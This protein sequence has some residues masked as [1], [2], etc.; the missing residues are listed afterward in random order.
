MRLYI[1]MVIGSIAVGALQG[2]AEALRVQCAIADGFT[3]FVVEFRD[4]FLGIFTCLLLRIT[5]DHV[6]TQSI[7]QQAVVF[8]R[9]RVHVTHAFSEHFL[10]LGPHEVRVAMSAA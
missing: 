10:G 3:R 6:N 9:L 1:A 7:V 2:N 8:F 5:H 4:Q